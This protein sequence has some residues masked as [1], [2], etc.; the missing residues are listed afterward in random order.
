MLRALAEH[1]HLVHTA[2]TLARGNRQR[3]QV[4]TS[5][6]SLRRF[7]EDELRRY[8]ASEIPYDKA[9]GYAIQDGCWNPVLRIQGSYS[10]VMGLP[11]E[12]VITALRAFG[13]AIPVVDQ[14]GHNPL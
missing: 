13:I 6:V 14:I 3:S 8:C 12:A 1:E 7:S 10:N 2:F 4:V 11:L 5:R 9:G